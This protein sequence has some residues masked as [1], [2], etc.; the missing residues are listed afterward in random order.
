MDGS[1]RGEPPNQPET[2]VT[3]HSSILSGSPF[4]FVRCRIV[5]VPSVSWPG[6]R[7]GLNDT[8]CRSLKEE[9]PYVSIN[10]TSANE[11]Q[12]LL[13]FEKC[14][15]SSQGRRSYHTSLAVVKLEGLRPLSPACR[16][17]L[18][19]PTARAGAGLPHAAPQSG[20]GTEAGT[21]RPYGW[22]IT[23]TKFSL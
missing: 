8:L 2:T 16:G 19:R 12:A 7:I 14:S 17:R 15:L 11:M 6:P 20:A 22:R 13:P 10:S 21:G 9:R 23:G 4:F 5:T 18:P 3:S 1:P